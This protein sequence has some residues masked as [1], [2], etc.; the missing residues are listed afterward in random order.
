LRACIS[1]EAVVVGSFLNLAATANWLSAQTTQPLVLVCAGTAESVA[2][3]DVLCAG[4]LCDLLAVAKSDCA[5]DDSAEV[6]RRVYRAAAPDLLEAIKSARNGRRL[7]A[8]PELREDVAYC[9]RRDVTELVA[10]L[11]RDGVV[12]SQ[13]L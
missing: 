8:N 6:A 5:L 3:E 12:R 13:P 9:L 4:A 2:L 1:A 11:G 10:L 7:L